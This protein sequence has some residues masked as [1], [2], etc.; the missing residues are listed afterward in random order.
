ML[1]LLLN[2]LLSGYQT[3]CTKSKHIVR[4]FHAFSTHLNHY[5]LGNS[6]LVNKALHSH[7]QTHS[8]PLAFPSTPIDSKPLD[9][10]TLTTVYTHAWLWGHWTTWSG[11]I[12][13]PNLLSINRFTSSTCLPCSQFASACPITL[14]A[15]SLHVSQ[16]LRLSALPLPVIFVPCGLVL[17][18]AGTLLFLGLLWQIC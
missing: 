8:K 12:Q 5:Y 2:Y 17:S 6:D 1:Q 10:C 3:R 18:W 9:M 16:P 7:H 11:T 4:S 13:H 14:Y 15:P